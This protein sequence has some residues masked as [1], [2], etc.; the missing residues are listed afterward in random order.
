MMRKVLL[1]LG[2]GAALWSSQAAAVNTDNYDIPYVWGSF[3]YEFPDSSRD[4]NN[5]KGFEVGGGWP[6]TEHSAIEGKFFDIERTREIDDNYDYQRTFLA[7]YVYDFGTFGFA[8]DWLPNFKPYVLG[9][10]GFVIDDTSGSNR[11]HFGMDAGGGTLVPLHFGNWDWGWAV[12]AEASLVA[13]LD[14]P[15]ES[16]SHSVLLDW[17]L[18][19]GLQIPLTPF[20]KTHQAAAPAEPECKVEVVNPI[21][22]RKDCATDVNGNGIPGNI[23]DADGDGVPDEM[24]QC[25]NTPAHAQVDVNGC[26]VAQVLVLDAVDFQT[27]SAILTGKAARTLDGIAEGLNSQKNV[28]VEVDGYTDDTGTAAYNMTLSQQRAEAVRQYLIG[29][30]IDSA[31]MT[32]QGFGDTQPLSQ[33]KTA[34]GRAQNRRVEFKIVID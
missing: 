3:I 30:G 5:G 33:N 10:P 34:E 14:H 26:M 9:G 21:T 31:R 22:G 32:T 20:F 27:N 18:S 24:D 15:D 16:T 19:V 8:S 12:R 6:L 4:S 17:H 1:A 2:A 7:N 13:Q 28:K 23:R 29:K 25:P 11:Y